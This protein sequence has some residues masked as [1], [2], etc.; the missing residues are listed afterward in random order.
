MKKIRSLRERKKK[1]GLCICIFTSIKKKIRQP[2]DTALNL[3]K[4]YVEITLEACL[5]P[6]KFAGN[7]DVLPGSW[8]FVLLPAPGIPSSPP[9]PAFCNLLLDVSCAHGHLKNYK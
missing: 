7:E 9:V 5:K 1:R 8:A 4:N 2:K 3:Q 6:T